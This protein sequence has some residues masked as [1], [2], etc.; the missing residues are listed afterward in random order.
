M[1]PTKFNL[2]LSLKT[3]KAG[4]P[5]PMLAIVNEPG[6]VRAASSRITE[7]HAQIPFFEV[8]DRPPMSKGK[9]Q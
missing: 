2:V 4:L 7:E 9:R 6:L 8:L 1:Q 5:G 3:A